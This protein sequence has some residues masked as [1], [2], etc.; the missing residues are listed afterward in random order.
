[1]MNELV[2]QGQMEEGKRMVRGEGREVLRYL[3]LKIPFELA[4]YF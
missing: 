1:M 2:V 4:L 3:A